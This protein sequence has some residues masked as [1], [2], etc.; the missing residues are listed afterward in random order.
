MVYPVSSVIAV[1]TLF[2]AI[3]FVTLCLRFWVRLRMRPTYVG[4]DD[5]TIVAA[6]ILVLAMVVNQILRKGFFLAACQLN[7]SPD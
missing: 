2:I 5:W 6:F 3:G 4:L 1:P 7:M